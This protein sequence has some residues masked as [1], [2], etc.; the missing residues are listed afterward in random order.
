MLILFLSKLVFLGHGLFIAPLKP[1]PVCFL[2]K[3]CIS[4]QKESQAILE[5]LTN[6]SN[7]EQG[8]WS[9]SEWVPVRRG[10]A[11]DSRLGRKAEGACPL[12]FV[13]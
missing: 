3:Y 2:F 12:S 10:Q 13:A 7:R 8:R 9:D 11:G 6:L 4:H 5:S 1:F